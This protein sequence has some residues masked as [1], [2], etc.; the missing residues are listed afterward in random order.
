MAEHVDAGL[1]RWVVFSGFDHCLERSPFIVVLVVELA[2][3][4]GIEDV[5]VALVLDATHRLGR[6]SDGV[7][8]LGEDVVA[9]ILGFAF[10]EGNE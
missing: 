9:V 4:E 7:V 8:D 6:A 1:D 2:V 5:T 3:G 10:E